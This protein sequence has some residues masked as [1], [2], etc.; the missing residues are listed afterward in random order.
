MLRSM[1]HANI[2][3]RSIDEVKTFLKL[4]F[5][6]FSTRGTG[7]SDVKRWEHFGTQETY[8]ALEE[9]REVTDADRKP[10]RDL[11]IN[12][13]GWVVEDLETLRNRAL[14]AGYRTGD[15]MLEGE[16]PSRKRVYIFDS[17]GNEWEFVEYLTD[18]DGK[19]NVYE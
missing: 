14:E 9:I 13:I 16:G 15:L 4:L 10:Y 3:V 17:V 18:D 1:E 12:H 11:G 6:E 8:V 7:D 2:T 5:P 19:R